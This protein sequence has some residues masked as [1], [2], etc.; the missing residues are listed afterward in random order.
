MAQPAKHLLYK[1]NNLSSMPITHKVEGKNC[2]HKV[3]L[4]ATPKSWHVR[5]NINTLYIS[6]MINKMKNLNPL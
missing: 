5:T 3:V 2:L 6:L 1:P 4:T